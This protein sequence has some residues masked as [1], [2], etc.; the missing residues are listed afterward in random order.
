MWSPVRHQPPAARV[1]GEMKT[2]QHD[3]RLPTKLYPVW[4]VWLPSL[5]LEGPLP[6]YMMHHAWPFLAFGCWRLVIPW[7]EPFAVPFWSSRPLSLLRAIERQQCW[8]ISHPS[9]LIPQLWLATKCTYG[10]L[11]ICRQKRIG[12]FVVSHH[13][14]L[15]CSS[16]LWAYIYDA[17]KKNI[18][19]KFPKKNLLVKKS[20]GKRNL[21]LMPSIEG[22]I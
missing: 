6:T 15:S 9:R 2:E 8:W 19:V 7:P 1:G 14:P 4:L 16:L 20:K 3:A 18:L 10:R 5:P 11:F 13:V 22:K 12:H 17:N 21:H